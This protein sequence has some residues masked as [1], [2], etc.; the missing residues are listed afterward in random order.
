MLI[1]ILIAVA[2]A[3][4]ALVGFIASRPNEFRITRSATITAPLAQVFERVNDFDHWQAWSPWARMDPNAKNSFEGTPS[5]VGAIFH[6][7][8]NNKVGEGGMTIL[9]S[10]Q[11][12][13]IRIQ[14]DFL[15]PF[16]ATNAVEFTFAPEGDGTLVTWSMSGRANFMNKAFTLVMGCDKMIGGQFEQGLAN[17]NAVCQGELAAH[18]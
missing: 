1:T 2:V 3:I 18:R 12:E 5:G 17:L 8:G 6:W 11:P 14:L 4:L 15:K 7:E 9:E 16:K 13:R 10:W